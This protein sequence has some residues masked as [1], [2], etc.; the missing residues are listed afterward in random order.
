MVVVYVFPPFS[1][2]NDFFHS[3]LHFWYTSS[4]SWQRYV[5][6]VKHHWSHLLTVHH[7]EVNW[8]A[9]ATGG[10][11]DI[12]S[13]I[14]EILK[15]DTSV[16]AKHFTEVQF[17]VHVMQNYNTGLRTYYVFV[18]FVSLKVAIF[19]FSSEVINV[20]KLL[21]HGKALWLLSCWGPWQSEPVHI[22]LCTLNPLPYFSFSLAHA[23]VSF[24]S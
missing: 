21:S 20:L 9:Q 17:K 8:G 5:I 13:G 12:E 6:H 2:G 1:S 23:R 4:T 10:H 19:F 24:Y 22:V 7:G 14:V 18:L 15:S 11:E 3:Y 16:P